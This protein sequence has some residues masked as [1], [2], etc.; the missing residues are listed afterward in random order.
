MSAP[1]LPCC[2]PVAPNPQPT[3]N[4][5]APPVL[6]RLCAPFADP[7]L[8]VFWK[9]VDP[10]FVTLNPLISFA[11]DT[12][13]A[14]DQE[15]EKAVRERMVRECSAGNGASSSG[16]SSTTGGGGGSSNGGNPT[17]HGSGGSSGGA[18]AEYPDYHF[19]CQV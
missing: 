17:P 14:A 10:R 8:P 12:K 13:L 16:G 5:R 2:A 4:P 3:L 7:A 6:F 19:I 11:G 9:R 1:T 15:E 18:A